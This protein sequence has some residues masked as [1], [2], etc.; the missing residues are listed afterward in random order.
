MQA[1][2]VIDMQADTL[3]KYSPKLLSAVNA[4]IDRASAGQA[5]IV[6]VQNTRRLRRGPVTSALADGLHV[7]S[8]HI[9]RKE[10]ANALT[11]DALMQLLAQNGVSSVT[12]IGVD[13][14]SCIAASALGARA[15]GYHTILPCDCVGVQNAARFEATRARL[16]SAGVFVVP[17]LTAVPS[18]CAP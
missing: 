9:F 4:C 7:V 3:Q 6:Y 2:L 13:G 14:N 18:D 10:R 5:L 8:P 17:A 12:I 11:N 15:Q 1:L 16:L